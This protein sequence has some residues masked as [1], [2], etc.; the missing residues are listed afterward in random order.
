MGYRNVVVGTDGSDSAAGAVRHAARL[1]ATFDCR[2][3]VVTGF[4]PHPGKTAQAQAEA[5]DEIR[6]AITESATA[7]EHAGDGLRIAEAEGAKDVRIRAEKGDP[8]DILIHV[9]E[10][11]G[12]DCIVVG[13]KGMAASSLFRLGNV[14]NKVSHHAP[15]DVIIVHTAD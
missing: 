5:P 3:T 2:L 12:A 4:T 1:A 9:A 6:W 8:A 15:C 10:D 11:T 7:E 13:S 14:P